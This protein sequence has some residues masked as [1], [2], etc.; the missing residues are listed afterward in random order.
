MRSI[1]WLV[2]PAP[3]SSP[4][5]MHLIPDHCIFSMMWSAF[6]ETASLAFNGA[7]CVSILLI[8]RNPSR[9]LRYLR[10]FF[11]VYAWM[12]AAIMVGVTA[13]RHHYRIV[14][15][16]GAFACAGTTTHRR[17]TTSSATLT[18]ARGTTRLWA[19]PWRSRWRKSVLGW[20]PPWW[21]FGAL[22]PRH[23]PCGTARMCWCLW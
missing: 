18:T 21:C 10:P 7:W 12:S 6:F 15:F 22:G 3:Q 2:D 8:A 19:S 17:Q 13:A 9:D 14:S 16:G 20:P 4:H 1:A 5:S 11:H 23:S